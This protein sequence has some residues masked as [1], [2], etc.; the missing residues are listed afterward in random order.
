MSTVRLLSVI[1]LACIVTASAASAAADDPL[2]HSLDDFMKR[3]EAHGFSGAVLVARNG[4]VLLREGYGMA[5]KKNDVPMRADTVLDIGSITKQ[6]TAAAVLR[7]EMDGKLGVNDKLSKYLPAYAHS[8]GIGIA[9][10]PDAFK[11]ITLHHL[12]SHQSGLPN[13]Y[14]D[15]FPTRKAWLEALLQ[16]KLDFEPGKDWD[17]SN[18][19]YDLL[20]GVIQVASSETYEQYLRKHLFKPAHMEFTGYQLP[21][22]P[23]DRIARY[24]DWTTLE[25]KIPVANPLERPE[26]M[27]LVG[28]GG[29]LSTVDDLYRWYQALQTTEIL[30]ADAKRK[31]FEPKNRD[32]DYAYGWDVVHTARHTLLI[33][34]GG[35]DSFLG[36]SAGLNIFVDENAVI[37]F[38][39]NTAMNASLIS[40]A[41][42][43]PLEYILFGGQVMMP[44]APAKVRGTDLVALT[45]SYRLQ[46]GGIFHVSQT[47]PRLEVTSDAPD[48]ISLLVFPDIADKASLPSDAQIASVFDAAERGDWPAFSK[49]LVSER[50]AQQVRE[51]IEQL[52][53]RLGKL[54]GTSVLQ[55]QWNVFEE[56]FVLRTYVLLKLE[57]GEMPVRIDRFT[58]G[59]LA[60]TGFQMPQHIERTLAPVGDREFSFWD[61]RLQSGGRIKFVT[62]ASGKA[63]LQ[64][65]GG[66]SSIDAEQVDDSSTR[67][68]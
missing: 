34:H 36:V 58:S 37:I 62:S 53:A 66:H 63:A 40:E 39:A 15:L 22:W 51:S 5:D 49:E 29:M 8:L 56:P 3:A 54:I 6:F 4:T 65:S 13:M 38:L 42:G 48:A 33:R 23:L 24:E 67:Q 1:A 46:S 11:S 57:H 32:G 60:I 2:A 12:L 50:H 55:Q 16:K 20:E 47:G 7:L 21:K 45:G 18:T 59:R 41:I 52:H 27:R 17:Y 35:F 26:T 19:N 14:P 61:F 43:S 64:V 10:T 44:P 9:E 25:R 28:S 30:S 68:H 31:F